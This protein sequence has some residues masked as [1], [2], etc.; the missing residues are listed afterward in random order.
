MFRFAIRN[1]RFGEKNS[2]F[3]YYDETREKSMRNGA[4]GG[5]DRE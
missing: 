4:C 3:L 2:A 5:S 1:E